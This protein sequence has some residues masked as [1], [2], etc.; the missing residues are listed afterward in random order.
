MYQVLFAEEELLV[1]S[2]KE[3]IWKRDGIPFT[4]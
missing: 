3:S 2:L 1:F 4:V